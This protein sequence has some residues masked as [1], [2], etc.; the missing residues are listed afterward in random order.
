MQT[1]LCYRANQLGGS[2]LS[3]WFFEL[4]PGRCWK[5]LLGSLL[6][7]IPKR[8][9]KQEKNV[10]QKRIGR[11]PG[12]TYIASIPLRLTPEALAAVERWAKR[13]KIENRSEALRMLVER[14][15]EK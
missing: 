10:H 2:W 8:M 5:H 14:G 7:C 1:Q 9:A 13:E 3:P 15:L 6:S 12:R 11:P 4:G